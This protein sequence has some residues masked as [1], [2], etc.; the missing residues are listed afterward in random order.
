MLSPLFGQLSPLR[1]PTK[2]APAG[3]PDV[4]AYIAAVEAADGQSLEEGVATA[5]TD[6][7]VGCK[8]DG[9]WSA[10][11]ASCILAGARTLSG[12]LVP[13]VGTAAT[14]FNFVS[15][16]YN[17]ETGLK[18]NGST[19]YLDSNKLVNDTA[20]DNAHISIYVNT[21]VSAINYA[22]IGNFAGTSPS[23][24]VG[25]QI[26]T[27]IGF[28]LKSGSGM[29]N[30]GYGTT[31]FIGSAR[32]NTTQGTYRLGGTST[33]VNNTTRTPWSADSTFTNYVFARNR[34]TTSSAVQLQSNGRMP[35][36]SIGESLDLAALDTRVST[37]MTDL[38]AAI[39]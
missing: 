9:I 27:N 25:D 36:Y 30:A 4:L 13:L 38:A 26:S 7:I 12:A 32:S 20:V 23:N 39:P 8:A 2:V 18:G 15:A 31:G 3:D 5:F 24:H 34:Y 1:V 14:N 37:L 22:Y 10:I 28:R 19:K 29:L 17:R 6:F 21:A 16:D 33:T 35:F 11:K